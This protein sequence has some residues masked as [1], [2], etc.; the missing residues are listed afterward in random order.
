MFVRSA[1]KKKLIELPPPVDGDIE[2]V[3]LVADL[4]IYKEPKAE[5]EKKPVRKVVRQIPRVITSNLGLKQSTKIESQ[6]LNF[7]TPNFTKHTKK[8]TVSIKPMS[9]KT[10]AEIPIYPGCEKFQSNAERLQC[11]SDKVGKHVQRKFNTKIAERL[12]LSGRQHFQVLFKVDEQGYAVDVQTN[13]KHDLLDREAQ[14]VINK[15]PQMIPGKN[16]AKP[17][18]VIYSLPII[19]QVH[20]Y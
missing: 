4:K 19:F 17:V 7:G 3:Y 14:R 20:C 8:E 10:V 11:F 1:V 6:K 2:D 16:R 12:G 15:I 5:I 13:A 9:I 18:K